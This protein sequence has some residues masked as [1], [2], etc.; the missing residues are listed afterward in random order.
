MLLGFEETLDEDG[1]AFDLAEELSDVTE[2]LG[3]LAER[4]AAVGNKV[5]R[6]L[7][8]RMVSDSALRHAPS[9]TAPRKAGTTASCPPCRV[10]RRAALQN[11]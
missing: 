6:Q 1:E 3:V 11:N 9:C 5:G 4:I 7:H 2:Q 8:E 10:T